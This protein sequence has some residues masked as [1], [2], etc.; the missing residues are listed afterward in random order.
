MAE[1]T[2]SSLKNLPTSLM[3]THTTSSSINIHP[4][5]NTPPTSLIITPTSPSTLNTL[6]P[7]NTPPTNESYTSKFS[8]IILIV[9]LLLSLF[10]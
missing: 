5:I 3:A 4:P 1:P 10:I 2:P 6:P 7:I 8:L 9:I